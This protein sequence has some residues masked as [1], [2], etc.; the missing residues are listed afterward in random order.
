MNGGTI[1]AFMEGFNPFFVADSNLPIV[2]IE[3]GRSN[4]SS[5]NNNKKSVY[6]INPRMS[7]DC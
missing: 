3:S 1:I 5:N 2:T 7:Q 4:Y 6:Q